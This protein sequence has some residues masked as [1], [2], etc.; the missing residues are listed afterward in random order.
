MGEL[1]KTIKLEDYTYKLEGEKGYEED[2]IISLFIK[3]NILWA[4]T[5][6]FKPVKKKPNGE[7]ETVEIVCHAITLS[8]NVSDIF[9]WACSESEDITMKEIPDLLKVA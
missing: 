6:I 2:E 7:Y 1:H 3:E 8:L 9:I 5:S 4:N